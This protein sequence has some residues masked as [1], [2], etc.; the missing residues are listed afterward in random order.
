MVN[1]ALSSSLYRYLTSD[2]SRWVK[3]PP[4]WVTQAKRF[5]APTTHYCFCCCCHA[6]SRSCM[7][8]S[9]SCLAASAAAFAASFSCLWRGVAWCGV[10]VWCGVVWCGVV[11][12]GVGGRGIATVERRP[13]QALPH[14]LQIP[15]THTHTPR[16]LRPRLQVA[17]HL[18]LSR[19][20]RRRSRTT[21]CIFA[22]KPAGCKGDGHHP[23]GRAVHLHGCACV[24]LKGWG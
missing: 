7:A 2:R 3:G 13:T 6:A 5:T 11:W 15:H 22:G 8:L 16:L 19:R 20:S 14:S 4:L 12:C 1:Y 17:I 10:V 9:L 23:R 18:L 24:V 21:R